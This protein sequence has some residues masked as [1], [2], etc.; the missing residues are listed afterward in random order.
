MA[1]INDVIEKIGNTIDEITDDKLS[2]INLTKT[3][4]KIISKSDEVK[5]TVI[6]NIQDIKSM[7]RVL[8]FEKIIKELEELPEPTVEDLINEYNNLVEEYNTKKEM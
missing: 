6:Q 5:N 8:E 2:K 3:E 1:T 7:I 4:L